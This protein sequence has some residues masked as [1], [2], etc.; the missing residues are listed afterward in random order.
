VSRTT[1]KRPPRRRTIFIGDPIDDELGYLAEAGM[2]G[3]YIA[4]VT[5]Y[6]VAQVYYRLRQ[7]GLT[8]GAYRNGKGAAARHIL[9]HRSETVMREYRRAVAKR[10]GPPVKTNSHIS[11]KN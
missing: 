6:S 1:T 4:S 5:G 2:C 11:S 9:Q 10:Y 7:I 3:K 8:L